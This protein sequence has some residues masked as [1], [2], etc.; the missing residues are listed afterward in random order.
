M[1][2]DN[3]LHFS[4]F[5]SSLLP[6]TTLE[7]YARFPF[8]HRI[9]GTS[10]L[11]VLAH[12]RIGKASA[13][14]CDNGTNRKPT[15]VSDNDVVLTRAT[16]T[17]DNDCPL[18]CISV[19]IVDQHYAGHHRSHDIMIYGRIADTCRWRSGNGLPDFSEVMAPNFG[20]K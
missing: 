8:E 11:Q 16:V 12:G 4:Q 18:S 19:D 7:N 20:E 5:T 1:F 10:R 15:A 9:T 6:I 17:A 2:Y 14:E 3:G 13:N